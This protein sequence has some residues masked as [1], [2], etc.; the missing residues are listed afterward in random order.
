MN[1]LIFKEKYILI[2]SGLN[3]KVFRNEKN[4]ILDVLD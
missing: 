1:L 4:K 2:I 3:N